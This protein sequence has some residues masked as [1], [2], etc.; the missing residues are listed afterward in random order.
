MKPQNIRLSVGVALLVLVPSVRP[1]FAADAAPAAARSGPALAPGPQTDRPY[2]PLALIPGGI[3]L[4][5][6][7]PGS[8]YLDNTRVTIPEVYNNATAVRVGSIVSIHNPSIEFHAAPADKNTGTCIILAAGGGHRTLNVGTEAMDFVPY[9][10][11]RGI[12]TVILRNRLALADGYNAQTDAVYD[13]LQAIRLVRAHAKEWNLDPKRIGIVGFS[14]GAELATPAAVKFGLWDDNN[15][16]PEDPLAGITARPDFI[17]DIYPGP[18]PFA[19]GRTAPAIPANTPPAFIAGAGPS[20]SDHA[21]WADQYFAAML[22]ARIPNVELH[23]YGAGAHPGSN[24]LEGERWNGGL[25]N[26]AN[27]RPYGTWPAR[28]MEWMKDLGFL[29][30]PGSETRAAKDVAIHMQPPARGNRGGPAGPGGPGGRR[31]GPGGPGA[32]GTPGGPAA[33]ASAPAP[34]GGAAGAP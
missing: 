1:L 2:Q 31:G 30:P 6:Y 19:P 14:A 21:A 23:I 13:A 28:F 9:F 18:S 33:P 11:E 20:D 5:L 3:V 34:R 4:T 27:G 25:N 12:S 26:A 8:P 32:P 16:K 22:A 15:N 29:T 7:P 17:G 10:A 24:D